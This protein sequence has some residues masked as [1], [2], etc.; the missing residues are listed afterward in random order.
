MR[1]YRRRHLGRCSWFDVRWHRRSVLGPLLLSR[2]QQRRCRPGKGEL[3][4]GAVILRICGLDRLVLGRSR[5]HVLRVGWRL[6]PA[7]R[8]WVI[9]GLAVRIGHRAILTLSLPCRFVLRL[10]GL[11]L[12]RAH[13]SLRECAWRRRGVLLRRIGTRRC[14]SVLIR[15]RLRIR[16]VAAIAVVWQT[17]MWHPLSTSR[18]HSFAI[19]GQLF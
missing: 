12:L 3:V 13:A 6:R 15:S 19:H 18:A 11:Q 17:L 14:L 9:S 1:V 7:G 4:V 8:S 5:I 10:H 2:S 16:I